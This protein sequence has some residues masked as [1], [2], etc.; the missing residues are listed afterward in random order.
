MGLEAIR[1]IQFIPDGD[2]PGHS[3]DK[4]GD[5]AIFENKQNIGKVFLTKPEISKLL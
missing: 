2:Q 1:S 4:Q 3:A 5:D